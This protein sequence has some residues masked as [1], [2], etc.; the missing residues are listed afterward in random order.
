[1]SFGFSGFA[2]RSTRLEKNIKNAQSSLW[3]FSGLLAGPLP[4][5]KNHKS[6]KG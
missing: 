4:K 6:E 2:R 5:M 3:V 1:L